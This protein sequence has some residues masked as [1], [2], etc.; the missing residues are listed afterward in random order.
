MQ[1][2]RKMRNLEVHLSS[3]ARHYNSV[4]EYFFFII[5]YASR[6]LLLSQSGIPSDCNVLQSMNLNVTAQ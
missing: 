3:M 4:N 2:V 5:M 1:T 6:V